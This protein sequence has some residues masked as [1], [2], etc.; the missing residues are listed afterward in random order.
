MKGYYTNGAY[1]G[2]MPNKSG[3]GGRWQFFATE[4]EYQEAY[5]WETMD[6]NER[7]AIIQNEY[8]QLQEFIQKSTQAS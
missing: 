1:V 8:E 3:Y 5:I 6:E 2:W 4:Q 7:Q